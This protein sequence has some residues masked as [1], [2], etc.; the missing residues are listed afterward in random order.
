MTSSFLSFLIDIIAAAIRTSA[1]V[2]TLI[3][4][5]LLAPIMGLD[6][7]SDC[8]GFQFF[9]TINC[10]KQATLDLFNV[11]KSAIGA[12]LSPFTEVLALITRIASTENSASMECK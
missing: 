1:F 4:F 6:K 7:Y 12:V 11:V 2:L 9:S 3:G 10:M 5:P 8:L